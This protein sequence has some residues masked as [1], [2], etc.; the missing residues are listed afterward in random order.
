MS[1]LNLF[2][3]EA[4]VREVFENDNERLLAFNKL[5]VD[6]ANDTYEEGISP[7]EANEK[8][9]SM[10]R[11][12]IGVNENSTKAEVR[13]AIRRNQQL[14]FDLIEEVVPKA[15]SERIRESKTPVIRGSK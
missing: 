4:R 12:L 8:I 10:F 5:M 1:K 2:N 11:T 9:V 7:K 3:F 14:L 13:K 6:T 15:C